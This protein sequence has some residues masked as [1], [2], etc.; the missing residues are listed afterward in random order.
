MEKSGDIS[1]RH[2]PDVSGTVDKTASVERRERQLE[3]HVQ[4][5]LAE[6]GKPKA[7]AQ[8]D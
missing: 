5:R 4:T 6:A 7:P 8:T 3:E 2:T 1:S